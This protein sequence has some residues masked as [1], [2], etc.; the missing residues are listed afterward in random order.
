MC[1]NKACGA[2]FRDEIEKPTPYSV[3]V[4]GWFFYIGLLTKRKNE[5]KQCQKE[6]TKGHNVL[7]IETIFH[8]HHLHS[9]GILGQP[10]LQHD[11]PCGVFYHEAEAKTMMIYSEIKNICYR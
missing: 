8:R 5:C 6:Q 3:E 9:E 2:Y 7:K 10:T 11:C 4:L 1:D